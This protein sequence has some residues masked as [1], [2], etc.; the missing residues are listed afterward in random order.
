MDLIKNELFCAAAIL[1]LPFA[2]QLHSQVTDGSSKQVAGG[3]WNTWVGFF[4]SLKVKRA[5]GGMSQKAA[6]LLQ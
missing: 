3:D 6:E 5:V 1:L 4:P 2:E